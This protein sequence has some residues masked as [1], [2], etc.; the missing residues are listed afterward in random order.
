MRSNG[1]SRSSSSACR[2]GS[3]TSAS[4]PLELEPVDSVDDRR[5]G[6]LVG[7]AGVRCRT[8]RERADEYVVDAYGDEL[9]RLGGEREDLV[10]LDADLAS[11]C[12]VRGFE[13]AYP[14]PL[15]RM[16]H[17]RAGHGLDGGRARTAR[18]PARRQLLRVLPRLARERADLQPGERGLEG[19][20]RAPLRGPDPGR[21]G[22]VAP[23]AAG[24]LASRRA[25]RTSTIVQPGNSDG[26]ARAPAL[27]RRGG[28]GER[29]DPARDR[30]VATQDRAVGRTSRP[31]AGTSCGRE[32]TRC[33]SPTGR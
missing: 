17:R 9:V 11:D 5:A 2:S 25:A 6:S 33:S 13:L 27:G 23:V 16:R 24:H 4:T 22:E 14:G 18:P 7:R 31:A 10:V 12:R 29:R 3:A 21:P 19:R 8:G 28:R 30:A 15:R 26:D 1:P 32:A 20:L